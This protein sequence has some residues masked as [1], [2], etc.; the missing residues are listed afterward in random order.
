M[1]MPKTKREQVLSATVNAQVATNYAESQ[2]WIN[3]TLRIMAKGTKYESDVNE[4]LEVCENY[5]GLKTLN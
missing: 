2:A 4:A 5:K 3:E 1:N